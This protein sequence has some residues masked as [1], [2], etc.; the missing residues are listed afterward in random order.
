MTS[1]KEDSPGSDSGSDKNSFGL[2]SVLTAGKPLGRV[3]EG[4][5]SAVDTLL[6]PFDTLSGM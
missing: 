3:L 4:P 1:P 5:G 2:S 6:L